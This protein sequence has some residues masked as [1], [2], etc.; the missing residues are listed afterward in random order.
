MNFADDN[1]PVT[2]RA[3]QFGLN[4]DDIFH[5]AIGTRLPSIIHRWHG[6]CNQQ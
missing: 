1:G 3:D 2:Q 4:L 6:R 5:L